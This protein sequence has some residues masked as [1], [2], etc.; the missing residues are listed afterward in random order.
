MKTKKPLKWPLQIVVN[1]FKGA[2]VGGSNAIPAISGGTVLLLLGIYDPFISHLGGFYKSKKQL[3]SA[4]IFLLPVFIGIAL[5][6]VALSNLLMWLIGVASLPTFALFAGMVLGSIPL[7]I[8]ALYKSNSNALEVPKASNTLEVEITQ[9]EKVEEINEPILETDELAVAIDE[10]VEE[11]ATLVE[12][13]KQDEVVKFKFTHI[14]PLFVAFAIVVA[15]SLIRRFV[16]QDDAGVRELNWQTGIMLA[17]MGVLSLGTIALPGL[18]GSL[19]LMLAG[20]YMTITNAFANPIQNISVLLVHGLG[21]VIGLL[22]AAKAAKF[23]LKKFKVA[24]HMAVAGF[25]L[26][27]IAAIFIASETYYSGTNAL[28]ITLAVVL[29]IAG[30]LGSFF[31]SKLQKGKALVS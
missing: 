11:S 29:F 2:I 31:I 9:D 28:G 30:T 25:L 4:L 5:G 27:S 14:I 1:F 22:S 21:A 15:L 3:F 12:T 13:S 10:K 20:Y 7:V 16:L 24:S 8:N 6:I 26:G 19:I 18:S 17:L 23:I